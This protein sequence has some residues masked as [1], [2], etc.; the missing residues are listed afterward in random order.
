MT[1][2]KP[3]NSATVSTRLNLRAPQ[4]NEADDDEADEDEARAP[5]AFE[6]GEECVDDQS[7]DLGKPSFAF[8]PAP[9]F[10]AAF[11]SGS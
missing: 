2:K 9:R 7:H 8:I 5:R 3:C 11:P 6:R 10:S 1:V 4:V